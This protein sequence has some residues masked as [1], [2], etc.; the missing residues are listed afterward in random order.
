MKNEELRRENYTAYHIQQGCTTH[1]GGRKYGLVV[2][3]RAPRKTL[4]CSTHRIF[5]I[6]KQLR[7]HQRARCA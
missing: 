5:K 7:I 3:L 6:R 1:I 4:P 2:G